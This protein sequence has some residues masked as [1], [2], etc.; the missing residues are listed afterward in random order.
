MWHLKTWRMIIVL[1]LLSTRYRYTGIAMSL[2]VAVNPNKE[3]VEKWAATNDISWN[4]NSLCNN[5][6]VKGTHTFETSYFI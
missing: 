4:F 3:A 5:P 2:L 6:K 1:F